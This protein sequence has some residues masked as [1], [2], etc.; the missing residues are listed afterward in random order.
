MQWHS[1]GETPV[2]RSRH[3]WSCG[4]F[5]RANAARSRLTSESGRPH[6]AH[7]SDLTVILRDRTRLAAWVVLVFVTAS[8]GGPSVFC[9]SMS[10]VETGGRRRLACAPSWIG[11]LRC[12]ANGHSPCGPK[13]RWPRDGHRHSLNAPFAH[14]SAFYL[15]HS[16]LLAQLRACLSTNNMRHR[17]HQRTGI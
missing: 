10:S 15:H 2:F 1:H 13:E 11:V 14:E 3:R 12:S 6:S 9:T 5:A 17:A 4:T 16:H 7:A 8:C